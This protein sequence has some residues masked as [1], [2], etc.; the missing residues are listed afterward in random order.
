[1]NSQELKDFLDRKADEYNQPSFIESDPIVVPHQFS[2]PR[3]IEIM[4]FFVSLFAW[5]NRKSI[6]NSGLKL[7]ELFEQEPYQFILNY[8]DTDL[9]RFVKF[10][11]RTFNATDLLFFIQL[12]KEHYDSHTSLETLFFAK[13]NF[14]NP[15]YEA[16]IHINQR[17]NELS[18]F[19]KRTQKHIASPLKNSS[20]KRLNMYFRW[21]VRKDNQGVDFGIWNS[22]KPSDL[23]CPLDVHVLRTSNHLG[24][25]STEKSDWKTT[26]ALTE[27]LREF[28][29]IDPI[30][31]DFALFGL[32]IHKQI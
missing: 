32:G 6:I 19:P 11:H 4:G 31:Y 22:I 3:D 14:N 1:L 23:Y 28:D 21:M 2:N 16:L 30:K 29:P 20:C 7:S 26:V 5:G 18:Y 15:V 12:F 17:I 24:L 9:K 8:S 27:T 10:V 13:S 25:T